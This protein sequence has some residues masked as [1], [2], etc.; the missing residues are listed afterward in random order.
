MAKRL[1]RENNDASDEKSTD[2]FNKK[3]HSDKFEEVLEKQK[4]TRGIS[5]DTELNVSDLRNIIAS[6][7]AIVKKETGKDFPTDVKQ[8]L[9]MATD[10]VFGSWNNPRAIT[11]KR[12]ND[13]R[14]LIGTA[15]NIQAMV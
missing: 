6:Y 9:I 2:F 12:L 7:K 8:Q 10:A 15:V 4:H 13:I 1:A 3:V 11:Y 14:G 5:L